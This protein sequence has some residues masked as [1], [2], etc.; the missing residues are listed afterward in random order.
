[1]K[2]KLLLLGAL[3][4]FASL[5]ARCKNNFQYTVEPLVKVTGLSRLP[6][7]LNAMRFPAFNFVV[8]PSAVPT[9]TTFE[10]DV[11]ASTTDNA[12]TG[13]VAT[14]GPGSVNE[15]QPSFYITNYDGA[16]R[17]VTLAAPLANPPAV[18]DALTITVGGTWYR[19]TSDECWI[20]VNPCNPKE[21]IVCT[22]QDYLDPHAT[23]FLADLFYY[24]KDDGQTWN[25]TNIVM[26]RDQGAT[27]DGSNAD[28]ESASDPSV[29]YDLKGNQ[30]ALGTNFNSVENFEEGNI[31]TKSTDGGASWL[32]LTAV[33]SDDGLVHLLDSPRVQT[34]PYRDNTIYVTSCDEPALLFFD[35]TLT[36]NVTIQISD[37]GGNTFTPPI[38]TGEFGLG[39]PLVLPFAPQLVVLNDTTNTLVIMTVIYD[40]SFSS[41]GQIAIMRSEDGGFSWTQT[42]AVDNITPAQP[43]DPFTS[44][45]MVPGTVAQIAVNPNNNFLYVSYVTPQF[46]QGGNLPGIG[47]VV[48]KDGGL[49]WSPPVVGNPN[50]TYTQ[51]F[52]PAIAVA[53]DGSVAVMYYDTRNYQGGSNQLLTDVWV[54]L[55]DGNLNF[56]KEFRL[57]PQSFDFRQALIRYAA[58]GHQIGFFLG[59]YC[60]IV[61]AGNDFNAVF[62]MTDP[63]LNGNPISPTIEEVAV[64]ANT[65]FTNPNCGINR[66]NT[67]FCKIKGRCS[68]REKC[69]T[70]RPNCCK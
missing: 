52:L 63:A 7:N 22:H 34:D 10:L 11:S 25:Q 26:S 28:F 9:T 49:T 3:C 50:S 15:G 8:D 65:P 66:Q 68:E 36:N 33:T 20:A 6:P 39:N 4:A 43:I 5:N 55:F 62:S 51:A 45:S 27:T 60:R 47:V 69:N 16:T 58:G 46:S 18:G 53:D 59:D 42:V 48:S 30:Y 35:P 70:C 38:V 2:K 12:Y 67:M 64:Q 14:W 17:I 13:F 31:L 19:N 32:P 40:A 24:T 29:A 1:M 56:K 44:L 23:G 57:T 54:S 37:D 61:N 21:K 41:N